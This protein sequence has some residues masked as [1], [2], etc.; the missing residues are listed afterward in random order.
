MSE[1]NERRYK[2]L[3]QIYFK[4]DI[5][6]NI[7]KGWGKTPT[8]ISQIAKK[9]RQ[10][11]NSPFTI[12][13]KLVCCM[14]KDEEKKYLIFH[15]DHATGEQIALVC[16]SCNLKINNRGTRKNSK[17]YPNQIS[18]YISDNQL[19]ELEIWENRSFELR[20]R[21]FGWDD[22]NSEKAMLE[23]DVFNINEKLRFL[24]K[25]IEEGKIRSVNLT[26]FELNRLEK[27]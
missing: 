10:L 17:R 27:I 20:K 5:Q 7:A 15:H 25:L 2:Y 12:D 26:E 1:E 3:N 14:C 21:V 22:L 18:L 24:I 19:K 11:K 23:R 8:Y 4:E 16:Q 13:N 9:F 6:A